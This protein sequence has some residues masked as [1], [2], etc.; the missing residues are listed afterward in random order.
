MTITPEQLSRELLRL[1]VLRNVPETLDDHVYALRESARNPAHASRI[2][3]WILRHLTFFPTPKEIFD[4]AGETL[5]EADIPKPDGEC[6]SCNGTGY[7]QAWQLVTYTQTASGGSHKSVD[8]ITD[9]AV[10]EKLRA[11]VDRKN[12]FLY[13]CAPRCKA[14]SYGRALAIA[15]EMKDHAA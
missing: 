9:P 14:C 15:E 4:A 11:K 10:A 13:D 12:Q 2:T 8:V 6:P 5:S 7:G 1:S 3:G